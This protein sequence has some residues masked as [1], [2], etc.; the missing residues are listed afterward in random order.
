M[1]FVFEKDIFIHNK[2]T[3]LYECTKNKENNAIVDKKF[4]R[5]GSIIRH[6]Q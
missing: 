4:S 5:K 2:T 6:L 3:R 1:L